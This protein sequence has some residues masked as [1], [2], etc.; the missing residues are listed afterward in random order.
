M[1]LI[2]EKNKLISEIN[3]EIQTKV[4]RKSN[5]KDSTKK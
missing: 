3:Q 1:L 4:Q 5:S 2:R